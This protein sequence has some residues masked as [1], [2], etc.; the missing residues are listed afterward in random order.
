VSWIS[1]RRVTR[2]RLL[3]GGRI[4]TLA[5][6]LAALGP[7]MRVAIDVKDAGAGDAVVSEVHNQGVGERVLFW[8]Q[9]EAA[10]RTAAA[11]APEL[12]ISLLRDT[13][14]DAELDRFLHDTAAFGAG[15]VSA[16]WSQVTGEL[17]ERCRAGGLKLYAWCRSESIDPGKL[18]LLD[19]LV[20][21]W[22]RAAR[23]AVDAL[24]G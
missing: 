18:A 12:E 20:T 4:P 11:R 2:A 22:P 3:G 1:E 19:G 13:S 14:T 15:G 9:H 6:A 24:G 17:A 5:E 21:D 16:H 23:L 8:S 10:V 7:T